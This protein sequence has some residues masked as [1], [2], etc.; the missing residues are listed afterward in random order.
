M[1]GS[2]LFNCTCGFRFG[3][4]SF[5]KVLGC[6][7]SKGKRAIIDVQVRGGGKSELRNLVLK[8]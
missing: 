4:V 5:F 1:S 7:L 8:V 3:G 2:I 6:F